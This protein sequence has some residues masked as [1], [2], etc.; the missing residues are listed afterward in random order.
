MQKSK[1]WLEL[2]NLRSVSAALD[3]KCL[4]I[5]RRPGKVRVANRIWLILPD[6]D[7]FTIRRAVRILTSSVGNL[8]QIFLRNHAFI[9]FLPGKSTA[10]LDD[11]SRKLSTERL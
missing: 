11:R 9:T 1:H 7:T 3:S 10:S 2:E 4:T 6:L 8:R 5:C